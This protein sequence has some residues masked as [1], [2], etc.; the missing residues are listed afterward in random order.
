MRCNDR[1]FPSLYPVEQPSQKGSDC[2]RYRWDC[3][4]GETC[5]DDERVPL[6]LPEIAHKVQRM[7]LRQFQNCSWLQRKWFCVE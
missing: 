1:V 3:D 4:Y 6:P 7:M 5:P 2:K